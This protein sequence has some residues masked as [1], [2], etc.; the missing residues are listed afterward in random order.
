MT[1]SRRIAVFIVIAIAGL[2][3]ATGASAQ[4]CNATVNVDF[5]TVNLVAGNV[6]D[7]NGTASIS[8]SGFAANETIRVCAGISDGPAM[9]RLPEAG[10]IGYRLYSDANRTV[11]WGTTSGAPNYPAGEVVQVNGGG[12]LNFNLNVYGRIF[13]GQNATPTTALSNIYQSVPQ[14]TVGAANATINPN[15]ATVGSQGGGGGTALIRATYEPVCSITANPLAFG[16]VAST[17]H[18]VDRSTSISATCS[19]ATLFTLA[20]DGGQAGSLTSPTNRE[21]RNGINKLWYGLYSDGAYALAWGAIQGLDVV[22][23]SGT[24]STVAIPVYG[25]IQPQTTP[26]AGLY[27]DTVIVTITY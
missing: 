21:M 2:A 10:N 25:R 12:S 6:I 7:Q 5:G 19:A 14:V 22:S 8:C 1:L 24:G 27:T 20:I 15:C 16:A 4:S 23:S 13:A 9:D 26:A 11:V 18:N 3:T 17:L